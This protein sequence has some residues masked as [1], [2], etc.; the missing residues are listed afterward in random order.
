MGE[1]EG[2]KGKKKERGGGIEGSFC[3]F[4]SNPIALADPLRRHPFPRPVPAASR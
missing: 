1:G 2:E 4:R 3:P